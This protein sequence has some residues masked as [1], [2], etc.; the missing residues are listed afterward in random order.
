MSA[1]VKT[2]EC[3]PQRAFRGETPPELLDAEWSMGNPP[4]LHFNHSTHLSGISP[5][6]LHSG[7]PG[8]GDGAV[9]CQAVSFQQLDKTRGA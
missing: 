8:C 9:N 5:R 1:R 7:V 4:F 3:K 6:H 2:M